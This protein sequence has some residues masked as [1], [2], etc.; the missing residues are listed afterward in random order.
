MTQAPNT[1]GISRAALVA[2]GAF[3]FIFGLGWWEI[4]V[5]IL[6]PSYTLREHLEVGLV[7]ALSGAA[8]IYLRLVKGWMGE[9]AALAATALGVAIL[10]LEY[11]VDRVIG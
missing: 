4:T 8:A 2:A 10:L 7:V 6:P 1:A 5:G 9:V 3:V 11:S